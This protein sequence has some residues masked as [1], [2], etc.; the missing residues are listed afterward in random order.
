M[1]MD[2]NFVIGGE[3]GQGVQSISYI[4]TKTL[5]RG[6]LHVFASQDYESRIR[7]GH[8]FT[9]IRV[10]EKPVMAAA[11]KA[12][13]L[14]ALNEETI[15]IHRDELSE[16]GLIL[17]DGGKIT[18]VDLTR[19]PS[20]SVPFET[21]AEEKG[22][23]KLLS[24]TVALGAALGIVGYDLKI[25]GASLTKFFSKKGGDIAKRNIDVAKAG[26]DYVKS[27]FKGD[28][29]FGLKPTA[30]SRRLLVSGNEAIALAALM[31][32]C[33]F[34]SSY[35]MTPSTGIMQY[36]AG[37]SKQFNLVVEQ[38]EDEISAI[39][40]ALGAS[41][42]GVR[43]LVATSGGGFSLMVEALGLA[44]M[45][46]TPIVIVEGQRPGPATGFPTRTEQGDLEFVLHAA[47][48]EFPR[49]ILAPSSVE[50]AF[51]LTVKAFNLADKYQ[52]PV[53][54]LSDE[55][56][57]DS[58]CTT[59][60]FDLSKVTVERGE[61]LSDEDA[62]RAVDYK[63][64]KLTSSGVSPRA[65]PGQQNVLVVT[66]SDEHTEEGHITE[67]A[68]VRID[69]VKKRL[70]KLEGLA[71]EIK[72]PRIY[73]P[74]KGKTLLVGWGSTRGAIEEVADRL[75]VEGFDVNLLHLT[76]IWPFPREAVSK[77]I[78]AAEKSLVVENN[79]T[80]QM[81]HLIRAETGKE[82]TGKILRFDGRPMTPDYLVQKFKELSG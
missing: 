73:G 63:R 50:E 62:V 52:V 23:S 44:G 43:S 45:T 59:E 27:N 81:A 1:V 76:E 29:S 56:L 12:D 47:Q 38:A 16:R 79:A 24:N 68:E 13:L 33:K 21:F 7:G 4:L 71:K 48:G 39:N 61:L 19:P 9:R 75:R 14:I 22:G 58:Y 18:G 5:A 54:I 78:D 36:L 82:A 31:V 20:F 15:D 35:P 26:Y 77:A 34:M 74:G 3:A 25:L 28:L 17:F 49:T 53:I 32:G 51:Y 67:S 70:R 2:F 41:F 65:L 10:S 69:M 42:A 37:K 66:D 46:E 55:H 6:G 30:G 8:N 80:G 57:A 40:M 11:E 64:H 60:N 72:N